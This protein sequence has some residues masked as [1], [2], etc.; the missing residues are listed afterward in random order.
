MNYSIKI[1]DKH[2]I[3]HYYGLKFT[4]YRP[5]I[6]IIVPDVCIIHIYKWHDHRYDIKC[7]FYKKQVDKNR[8]KDYTSMVRYKRS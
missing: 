4:Q 1:T 2:G 5:S 3:P 8:G 7:F 6:H